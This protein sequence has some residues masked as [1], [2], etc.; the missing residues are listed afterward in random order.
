MLP[1]NL[2]TGPPA[3]QKTL[4]QAAAGSRGSGSEAAATPEKA[5][6]S[7][8]LSQA[9]LHEEQEIA[10]LKREL[11]EN[12]ARMKGIEAKSAALA[13]EQEK[14]AAH[15]HREQDEA[16]AEAASRLREQEE[17]AKLVK[18]RG[19]EEAEAE[20]KL[21]E[22]R[23]RA[24]AA[25][26]QAAWLRISSGRSTEDK[27]EAEQRDKDGDAE[28]KE[29]QQSWLTEELQHQVRRLNNE[30]T[31]WW[32]QSHRS[33]EMQEEQQMA[34]AHR[35]Q[36]QE[37]MQAHRYREQE[38]QR[39]QLAA[40]LAAL[41][42]QRQNEVQE[43]EQAAEKRRSEERTMW[44]HMKQ[45]ILEAEEKHAQDR[46][47]AEERQQGELAHLREELAVAQR[48]ANNAQDDG[49][50]EQEENSNKEESEEENGSK[51]E[52]EEENG[53]SDAKRQRCGD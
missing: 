4:L 16:L 23:E 12:Q 15:R 7:D 22:L 36:E 45:E 53:S 52:S 35:Y 9:V 18:R 24:E 41:Q 25:R 11:E 29:E 5:V 13:A 40:E 33:K 47:Q 30:M 20:R 43:A 42:A 31:A 10:R 1:A 28:H 32:A 6:Q 49:V 3:E 17:E 37:E 51:E 26:R 44:A 50:D 34:E 46:K 14:I 48:V 19:E 8:Q 2:C 38:E 27:A 21:Q 39:A